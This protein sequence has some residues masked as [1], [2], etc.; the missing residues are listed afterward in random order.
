MLDRFCQILEAVVAAGSPVSAADLSRITGLPR[1]TSYRL[2][3]SL[4]KH[5]LLDSVE[6][7]S[8]YTLGSRFIRMALLSK[9]DNDLGN[10]T[11]AILKRLVVETGEAAF[12]SRFRDG[13]IDL[14]H[15]E[16]PQDGS[17][18]F[19]HPGF[20]TRP[21]HACSSAKAIAA[22]AP[23]EVR[24]QLLT[25]AVEPFTDATLTQRE[26]ILD[27][28]ELTRQRGYAL[29]AEEMDEGVVSIAVP[30]T[31]DPVGIMFSLGVVGP[32]RRMAERR[33][34]ELATTLTRAAAQAG[35]AIQHFEGGISESAVEAA[36]VQARLS[37]G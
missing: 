28:L 32:T 9:T 34:S 6:G 24:D 29:C 31:I 33:I 7:E 5:G 35:T 37:F 1:P 20:G 27:E 3:A 2:V 18:G 25:C 10:S 26:E 12:L 16:V 13:S 36:E 17:N 15:V 23:D 4:A 19:I 30:V 21:V 22:Y 11:A 8:R 14:I